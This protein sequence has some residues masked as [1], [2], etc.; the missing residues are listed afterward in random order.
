ML[1]SEMSDIK[2][3]G[4]LYYKTVAL[5][6]YWFTNISVYYIKILQTRLKNLRKEKNMIEEKDKTYSDVINDIKQDINQTQLD[7]MIN[8]NISLVNLYYRI[9]KVLYDK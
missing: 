8:A 7:I 9:G 5:L 1:D 6:W 3:Q 4:Y 2:W